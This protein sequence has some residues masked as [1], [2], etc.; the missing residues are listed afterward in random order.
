MKL[1][2]LN[3]WVFSKHS[4]SIQLSPKQGN[5]DK[6]DI[7]NSRMTHHT[8]WKSSNCSTRSTETTYKR[9]SLISSPNLLFHTEWSFCK[10]KLNKLKAQYNQGFDASFHLT[11]KWK[12][13]KKKGKLPSESLR[14]QVYLDYLVW[15]TAESSLHIAAAVCRCTNTHHPPITK[16]TTTRVIITTS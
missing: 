9:L 6:K 5:W 4:Y 10:I 13:F 1:T 8:S 11:L 2:L 12:W 7:N 14:L 15:Y 3:F 16:Q